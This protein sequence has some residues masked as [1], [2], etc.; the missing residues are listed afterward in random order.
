MD[1]TKGLPVYYVDRLNYT[2]IA[3]I[4]RDQFLFYFADTPLTAN[5]ED[6]DIPDLATF[7]EYNLHTEGLED[8]LTTDFGK[9]M[10]LGMYLEHKMEL[11]KQEE[12][13]ALKELEGAEEN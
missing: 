3:Y 1:K 12:I 4:L 2:D 6:L 10:I 11:A 8:F 7:L 5:E 9:G 13:A